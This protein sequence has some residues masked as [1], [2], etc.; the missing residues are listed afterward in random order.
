[1]VP[2]NDEEEIYGLFGLQFLPP[3]AREGRALE[4]D[5]ASSGRVRELV[6]RDDL[7][8]LLHVHSTYSDGR[9]FVIWCRAPVI[10]VIPGSVFRITARAPTMQGG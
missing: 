1:M 6:T 8:G 9:D 10:G 7:K 2:V 4:I 3:E 5:L